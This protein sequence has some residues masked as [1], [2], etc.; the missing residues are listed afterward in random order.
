VLSQIAMSTA[1]TKRL[2]PRIAIAI[3]LNGCGHHPSPI[4]ATLAARNVDPLFHAVAG[5]L[6][7]RTKVPVLL[8][9]Q[10]PNVGQDGLAIYPWIKKADTL[11]YTVVLSFRG[12]PSTP[13]YAHNNPEVADSQVCR[14]ATMTGDMNTVFHCVSNQRVV[15]RNGVQGCF[16]P[17]TIGANVGDAELIFPVDYSVYRAAIKAGSQEEV[18]TLANQ[19]IASKTGG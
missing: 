9:K 12:I 3:L 19:M 17:S 8:P 18:V 15:L 10:M 14:F 16:S 2:V 5:E 4:S 13:C 1:Y 11:T 6:V 7:E